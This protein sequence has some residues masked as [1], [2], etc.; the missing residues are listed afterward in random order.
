MKTT[1]ISRIFSSLVAMMIFVSSFDGY[2]FATD[3]K[4]YEIRTK[5]DF[6]RFAKECTLDSNSLGKTYILKADIMLDEEISVPVFCG[7]FDG[8]G[9]KISGLKIYKEASRAG[10]FRYVEESGTIKNLTVEGIVTPTGTASY[11]GG[12]VGVNK[13]KIV[14]CNFNGT[15]RGKAFC[16]GIAGLN[17]ESGLIVNCSSQGAVQSKNYTGGICGQNFGA[18]QRCTNNSS[19]NT[20]NYDETVDLE[21]LDIDEIYSAEQVADIT[22]TGGITGYSSGT[23]QN[24]VNNGAVGYPHVGY[25]IGGI[26]GRQ[27]G[28]VSG[29]VNFGEI[30][31]RKDT[32]GIVGQAEPYLSV[33][34]SEN[35]LDKLRTSL[36]DMKVILDD[37]L[38]NAERQSDEITDKT[39]KILDKLE[40]IRQST[41]TFLTETDRIVNDNI[42]SLNEFSSRLYELTEKLSPVLEDTSEGLGL[43]SDAADDLSTASEY[44]GDSFEDITPILKELSRYLKELSDASDR[45]QGGM[46]DLEN[47]VGDDEDTADAM[48][49]ISSGLDDMSNALDNISTV[50][51]NAAEE[52]AGTENNGLVGSFQSLSESAATASH[53]VASAGESVMQIS[54]MTANGNYSATEHNSAA[55]SALES[56]SYNSVGEVAESMS[57]LSGSLLQM[58]DDD[59][60]PENPE[61]SHP[62]ISDE[63]LESAEKN[64]T[65]AA[66]YLSSACDKLVE[67]ADILEGAFYDISDIARYFSKKDK[68]VFTGADESFVEK[69]KTL[70]GELEKL[71]DNLEEFTLTADNTSDIFTADLRK[72]NDKAKEISDILLELAD[73]MAS[74]STDLS[75]YTE[76]ISAED[77]AGKSDGKITE[78][79][80]YGKVNGDVS[81]GGIAGSMAVE[82]DFDPEGDIDT[83][84]E[85][86]DNFM[87]QS[88]TVIRNSRNFGDVTSKKNN[89]GGIAGEM[90]TGCLINC[91]GFGNVK[92]T[93]GSYAGGVTG[94]SE[95][96]ISGCGAK[97][98]VSGKEFVGGIAGECN[99][100]E[101]CK[102]F[103]VIEAYS[104]K[105][106]AIAGC[107]NGDI[108]ENVFIDGG[109][110]GIDGISYDKKAYPVE[111]EEMSELEN[112]PEDF[113]KIKLVFVADDI[114]V[115]EKEISY[116]GKISESALPE[117]PEKT[118]YY[119]KWEDF[120]KSGIRFSK[121]INAVYSKYITALSSDI[122]SEGGLPKII[123]E[124]IF[125]DDDTV[126]AKIIS[127]D[128]NGE[129]LRIELPSDSCRIRYLPKGKAKKTV[130]YINGEK[131]E[132]EIDGSYL[133][134][135]VS[136]KS[137]ELRA[138]KQK[139]NIVIYIVAFGIFAVVKAIVLVIIIRKR[140][141]KRK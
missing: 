140:R 79:I 59:D 102:G 39:D 70:S 107:A 93:D 5:A 98:Y 7:T 82:Y 32:G 86:S 37:T 127:S 90:K 35:T 11:C 131:A 62:D 141:A 72:I 57:D 114:I 130:L 54:E 13:G 45:I 41:D 30:N 135:S 48:E 92:S 112:L 123:A 15:I 88:K 85:R 105:A 65:E 106:G 95:A 27:Q 33:L 55:S 36:D 71:I 42:N 3:E 46:G 128:E 137:V 132:P 99:D 126:S 61:P 23:V 44:A 76:D 9:H 124:G 120:T 116:N 113:L 21:S 110:G 89:V 34:F 8:N 118:G 49:E 25:N 43:L 74:R 119:A 125:T 87:Y 115:A 68:I 94:K 29:C 133:V 97:C 56:L 77:E 60:T 63:D 108:S 38:D 12:I 22:D 136:S 66:R 81:V 40:D 134:F 26:I 2:L 75:D 47:S 138:E 117:I 78:C 51:S 67:A 104:E 100:I 84:G 24:C 10:L 18:I 17:E 58:M 73:E 109:I 122:F 129:V 20:N 103:A 69:R 31:G 96:A 6:E 28:F 91:Y 50:S 121:E 19:V 80:N 52:L 16:G 64:A 53:N 139:T 111:Y 14:R 1:K 101:N 4:Q 83:V